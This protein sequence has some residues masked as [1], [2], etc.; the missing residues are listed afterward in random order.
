VSGKKSAPYILA[1][2]LTCLAFTLYPSTSGFTFLDQPGNLVKSAA[3]DVQQLLCCLSFDKDKS[4]PTKMTEN[5]KFIAQYLC[6]V[7]FGLPRES[8]TALEAQAQQC[9]SSCLLHACFFVPFSP[10]A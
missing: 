4:P 5:Q 6:Q 10:P 1:G 7:L 2:T 9:Q 3:H 8:P